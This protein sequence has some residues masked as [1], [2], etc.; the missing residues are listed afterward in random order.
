VFQYYLAS[1]RKTT[2]TTVTFCNNVLFKEA[3]VSFCVVCCR[4]RT[5]GRATNFIN[6]KY[7]FQVHV[8]STCDFR[9]GL[10]F[11]AGRNIWGSIGIGSNVV[12][13]SY[14]S[15]ASDIRAKILLYVAYF[16]SGSHRVSIATNNAFCYFRI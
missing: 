16:L 1:M 13:T 14:S 7:E 10:E 9:M 12:Q 8:E 11:G 2:T 4:P 5:R 15:T 6:K 3:E